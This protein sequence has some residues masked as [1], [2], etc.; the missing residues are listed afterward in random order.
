MPQCLRE[1]WQ[2]DCP[3]VLSMA[4]AL[5]KLPLMIKEEVEM[6]LICCP[7]PVVLSLNTYSQVCLEE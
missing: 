6:D 2:A 4:V 3:N 7:P 1:Q 5:G